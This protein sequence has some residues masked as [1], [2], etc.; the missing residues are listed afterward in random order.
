MLDSIIGSSVQLITS[1]KVQA[2]K[3]VSGPVEESMWTKRGRGR[4]PEDSHCLHLQK[5]MCRLPG[6]CFFKDLRH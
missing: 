1:R 3:Q 2:Y 5:P 4:S 6:L